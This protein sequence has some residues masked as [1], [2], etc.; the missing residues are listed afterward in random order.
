[1]EI[2]IKQKLNDLNMLLKTSQNHL[3][4]LTEHQKQMT[5]KLAALTD[6]EK[7]FKEEAQKAAKAR[8]F[9]NKF[10]KPKGTK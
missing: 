7:Y 5:A 10:V 3:D 8:D 4:S 2:E 1:M 6:M 9:Y